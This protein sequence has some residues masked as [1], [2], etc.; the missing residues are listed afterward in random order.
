[1]INLEYHKGS[2]CV[3]SSI[4]CQ[5]GYCAKCEIYLRMQSS[6]ETGNHFHSKENFNELQEAG[7]KNQ[8]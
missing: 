3:Y 6:F 5:E 2:F 7:I 8:V 4:F 1:M